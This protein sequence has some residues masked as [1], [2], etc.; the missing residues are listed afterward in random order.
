MNQSSCSDR[1]FMPLRS[2]SQECDAMN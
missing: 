1:K 2:L